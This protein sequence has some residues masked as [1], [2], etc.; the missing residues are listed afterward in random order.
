MRIVGWLSS[1]GVNK[2]TKCEE[3][4]VPWAPF[5]T[6]PPESKILHSSAAR[7]HLLPQGQTIWGRDRLRSERLLF[8]RVGM[9]ES[10]QF[11]PPHNT[12]GTL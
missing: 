2:Q 4:Q 5:S 11:V 9:I 7:M 1:R 6:H 8:G 3:L 12:V 10:M